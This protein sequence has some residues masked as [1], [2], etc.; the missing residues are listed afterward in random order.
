MEIKDRIKVIRKNANITQEDFAN[1]LGVSIMTIRRYES[2]KQEPK[3]TTLKKMA[4][5][6]GVTVKDILIP[7]NEKTESDAFDISE[8]RVLTAFRSLN[9]NGQKKAI[10][11]IDDLS[12]NPKY[13]KK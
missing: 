1:Q 4:E 9:D 6:L 8:N 12:E 11:Y 13:S 5:I 2:G 3:P 10:E 7:E